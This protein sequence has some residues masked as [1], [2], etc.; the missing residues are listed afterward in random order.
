M[1]RLTAPG[2]AVVH[3]VVLNPDLGV[4]VNG[5]RVGVLLAEAAEQRGT[6]APLAGGAAAP[7]VAGGPLLDGGLDKVAGAVAH[8]GPEEKL[9]ILRGRRGAR[10]DGGNGVDDGRL[11]RTER[12]GAT[13]GV[14][15]LV[16]ERGDG[17]QSNRQGRKGE[18]NRG[19]L[20]VGSMGDNN[21]CK[22]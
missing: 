16:D 12:N 4:A 3:Q 19:L 9:A 1:H 18:K 7:L 2:G 17:R 10:N 5:G 11:G 15:L 6:D 14:R 21:E 8:A 20:C 22:W 13:P